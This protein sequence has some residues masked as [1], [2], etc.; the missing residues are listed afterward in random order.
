MKPL[1]M[2]TSARTAVEAQVL[3]WATIRAWPDQIAQWRKQP[4]PTPPVP[5]SPGQLKHSEN[6]TIAALW[7]LCE[8]LAGLES[9]ARCFR[10]W[11][12]IAAP[13]FYGRAGNASSLERY[14]QEGAWGISPHMIPHHS[15]HAISGTISQIFK[16]QGPNFG[17][18]NGPHSDT[19]GWLVAATMLSENLVPGIWLVMTGHDGE[20]IPDG[21]GRAGTQPQLEAVALAMVG[22][23]HGKSGLRVRLAAEDEGLS[24]PANDPFLSSMAPFS[25]TSLID[26]LTRRDS[27]PGGMWRLPGAGWLEI[28]M[29]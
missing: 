16:M 14:R 22:E 10:D 7:A 2:S 18:G 6:Q 24:D 11:G 13:H 25:L 19:E 1:S 20:Y 12:V 28:E 29:R 23:Q 9:D 27:P 3:T 17:V 5:I 21:P 4:T 8:A 26:E 15:L